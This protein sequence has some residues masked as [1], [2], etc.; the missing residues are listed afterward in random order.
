MLCEESFCDDFGG[1]KQP[2]PPFKPRRAL[3]S[4][5]RERADSLEDGGIRLE[6]G[7]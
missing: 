3:E 4:A 1:Q 7:G 2:C 5:V 6:Q